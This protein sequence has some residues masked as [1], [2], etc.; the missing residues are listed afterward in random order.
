MSWMAYLVIN[1]I[2]GL[3]SQQSWNCISSSFL[4]GFQEGQYGDWKK[5][6]CD[7]WGWVMMNWEGEFEYPWLTVSRLTFVDWFPRIGKTVD[8]AQNVDDL[9]VEDGT[10]K[11]MKN[12]QSFSLWVAVKMQSYFY[13]SFYGKID[14][15]DDS[16]F[17]NICWPALS[18]GTLRHRGESCPHGSS[19][20]SW[21][22]VCHLEIE[23]RH[24]CPS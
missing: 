6:G 17:N 19:P 7:L 22:R 2:F 24:R 21:F 5:N 12:E 15:D 20:Q 10:R 16:C 1:P 4:A 13:S 11:R 8:H 14:D 23:R 3:F 18:C 9:I